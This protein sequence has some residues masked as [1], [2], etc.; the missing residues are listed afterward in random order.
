MEYGTY[1]YYNSDNNDW[2]NFDR[3]VRYI[4]TKNE[5]P[6]IDNLLYYVIGEKSLY[7]YNLNHKDWEKT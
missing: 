2:E 3:L 7:Q 5:L 4:D 6:D 1:Y